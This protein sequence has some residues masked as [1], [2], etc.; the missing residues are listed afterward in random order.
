[1]DSLV[2]LHPLCVTPMTSGQVMCIYLRGLA[3]LMSQKFLD[4][5]QIHPL[6]QQ[7]CGK[8]MPKVV[9]S[10]AQLNTGA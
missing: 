5:P 3:A 6:V 7:M 1:M 2:L 8:A 10:A 9:N 4:V